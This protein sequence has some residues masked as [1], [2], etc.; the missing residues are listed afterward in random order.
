[1][2]VDSPRARPRA[3]WRPAVISALVY[4]A[5]TLVIGR[6]VLRHLS[7]VVAGDAGDPLLTAAILRWNATHLPLTDAWWQFPI[8]FPSRDTLAFSEHLLG[9]SVLASPL[10]WVAGPLTSYNLITLLTFPLCAISMYALVYRLTRSAAGAFVAG[11][12]FGFAPY[13]IAQLPHVQMLAS[14]YA[15]L[16]LLGLHEYV[17][18][19]RRKWLVLYGAAW[20]LQGAANMYCVFFFS[21]LVALWGLWFVLARRRWRALAEIVAATLVAAIPLAVVLGKYVTVHTFHGFVRSAMEIQEFSAD[22]A[23]VLC[24]PSTLSWWGWIRAQCGPEGD[25]FPGVAVFALFLLGL[26]NVLGWRRAVA[27]RPASTW[28]GAIALLALLVGLVYTAAVAIVGLAGPTRFDLGVIHV[29]MSSVRRE[30]AIALCAMVVALLL[31]PSVPRRGRYAD[32]LGFYVVAAIVTWVMALGPSITLMGTPLHVTGPFAWLMLLPGANGLRVPAR[33]WLMTV[34]CLS[35]VAGMVVSELLSNRRRAATAIAVVLL[36]CA[37]FGDGLVDRIGDDPAPAPLPDE[38]S[39]RGHT[40]MYLP[41]GQ[42][43]DIPS[44]YRAV[45]DGWSSVN[46]YSGYTP[47]YYPAIIEAV[48]SEDPSLFEPFQRYGPLDV[49]VPHDAPRLRSVI[50]Q[51]P[52]VTMVGSNSAVTHYRLPARP[53]GAVRARGQQVRIAGAT[54]TCAT[55]TEPQALDGRLLTVWRCPQT[56][57][58]AFTIDLGGV[59]TVGAVV[60]ALG[61]F[62]TEFPRHLIVETSID[63]RAWNQQWAGSG[64]GPV[65]WTALEEP[66]VVPATVVFTPTAARF[67]R[68]RQ[69]G[70]DPSH[71]WT[72]AELQVFSR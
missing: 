72:I 39:L 7:S 54:A 64:L 23:A 34:I 15:P 37:V 9:L 45:I 38:S 67:I 68:L 21:A 63:G 24:A 19:G 66:Q 60:T 1:M 13:R 36:G 32:V 62:V 57:D 26:V 6:D 51:Q 47:N 11:V 3:P 22:V 44:T 59:A 27:S 10:E 56:A 41:I 65:V 55:G 5:A 30:G 40:V 29:S 69:T 48:R 4:V 33:F 17:E 70:R 53:V 8:F 35:V 61:P 31:R 16:A 49:I 71:P 28:L 43:F 12:A 25:L 14:F 2:I 46:G 58:A 42:Y 20:M 18:S 50:E 52:G